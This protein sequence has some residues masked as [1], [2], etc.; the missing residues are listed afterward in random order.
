MKL[1]LLPEA[2]TC[3][4]LSYLAACRYYSSSACYSQV[5]VS[6]LVDRCSSEIVKGIGVVLLVKPF[7]FLVTPPL[8]LLS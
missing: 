6:S 8:V 7:P 1:A 5:L 2:Y 3:C 4:Y